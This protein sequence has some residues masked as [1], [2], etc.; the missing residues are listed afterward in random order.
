MF[1]YVT[2]DWAGPTLFGEQMLA[3][4]NIAELYLRKGTYDKKVNFTHLLVEGKLTCRGKTTFGMFSGVGFFA[5]FGTHNGRPWYC[6][7]LLP[8]NRRQGI[9][10]DDDVVFSAI[11][12]DD[13]WIIQQADTA[14]GHVSE[15]NITSSN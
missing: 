12:C 2:I 6:H 7:F 15:D 9:I 10:G 4:E 3:M 5:D 8:A 1:Q 11:P 13:G 14:Q